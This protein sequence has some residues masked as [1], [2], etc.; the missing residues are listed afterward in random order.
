MD[1]EDRKRPAS[2]ETIKNLTVN[3]SQTIESTYHEMYV[4]MVLTEASRQGILDEVEGVDK[5]YIEKYWCPIK[6]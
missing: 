5:D 1:S 2:A 4:D 6:N 3:L